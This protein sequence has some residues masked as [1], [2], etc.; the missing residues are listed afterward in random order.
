M[1]SHHSEVTTVN[2]GVS[3]LPVFSVHIS[4]VLPFYKLLFSL[5]K[6]SWTF[7]RSLA[8]GKVLPCWAG[9]S[10]SVYLKRWPPG[11]LA[12]GRRRDYFQLSPSLWSWHDTR[13]G[14]SVLSKNTKLRKEN[15]QHQQNGLLEPVCEP[16]TW[17]KGVWV[18]RLSCSTCWATFFF[19]FKPLAMGGADDSLIG[20]L[21][22][23]TKEKTS[24]I[25][26]LIT[27][28]EP[29]K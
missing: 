27:G 14:F 20:L 15:T 19:F 4:S 2:F 18:S 10:L 25:L 22:T 23:M 1:Y 7:Y 6:A 29:H 26:P 28:P 21:P 9:C 12:W 17:Q 24:L 5:N 8:S 16:S 11:I 3:V 13:P